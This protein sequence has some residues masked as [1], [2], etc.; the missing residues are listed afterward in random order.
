MVATVKEVKIPKKPIP[1][2]GSLRTMAIVGKYMFKK[3]IT[4]QYPEEK[5]EIPERFRYRIFLAPEACIGCT[6]C[7]QICPN[8]SIKMEKWD[9][10]R[11]DT[12]K[13]VIETAHGE[14]TN[15]QNKRHL[16]PDVNFG[17]CTVCRQCEEICP[18]DAIY[19][20]HEFEDA[21]TRNSFT[22]SPE[23]LTMQEKDVIK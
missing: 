8:H 14:R 17:T 9:F 15:L 23:E 1:I 7:E 3:P 16:Y 12:E 22:Y 21:R 19:L 5:G 18:T 10:K 11:E 20:T 6:L 13:L 4:T 2:L